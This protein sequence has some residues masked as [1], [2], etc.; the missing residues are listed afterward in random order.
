MV[1]I[2]DIKLTQDSWVYEKLVMRGKK[3]REYHH[4]FIPGDSFVSAKSG[5][6]LVH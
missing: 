5:S 3:Q 4:T 1:E 6:N 2:E